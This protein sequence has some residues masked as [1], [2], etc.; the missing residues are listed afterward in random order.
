MTYERT[1]AALK[2]YRRLIEAGPTF[3]DSVSKA[4]RWL[5]ECL[6]AAVHACEAFWMDSDVAYSREECRAMS[7]EEVQ[8]AVDQA[9]SSSRSR[10]RHQ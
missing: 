10:Q 8:R 9:M 2:A 5:D 3:G 6:A 1:L 4:E 7:I